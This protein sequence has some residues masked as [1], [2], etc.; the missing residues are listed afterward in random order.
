MNH[1][2]ESVSRQLLVCDGVVGG[3]H[4]DQWRPHAQILAQ[5]SVGGP[6]G[7]YLVRLRL[8]R[9]NHNAVD[10]SPDVNLGAKQGVFQAGSGDKAL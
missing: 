3:W 5:R 9:M 4:A 8:L 7:Q 10:A 6:E 1:H 2:V